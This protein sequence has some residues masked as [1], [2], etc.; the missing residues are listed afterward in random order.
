MPLTMQQISDLMKTGYQGQILPDSGL[1]A[2]DIDRIR[3]MAFEQRG[4]DTGAGGDDI[5]ALIEA[6]LAAGG[7]G[8]AGGGGYG[9]GAGAIPW[10][11][12]E[13]AARLAQQFAL[14]QMMKEQAYRTEQERLGRTFEAGEAEKQREFTRQQALEELKAERQRIFT[15]MMGKDPVRAAL[16]AMG[17]GGEILPGGERFV[18]LPPLAG[19]AEYG[20]KAAT[21]LSSLLGR[22]VGV[23]EQGVTGL[24]EVYK[25]A[26]AYSA[27]QRPGGAGRVGDIEAARTML[28]SGF[29]VGAKPGAGRPGLSPEE[30]LRK[31]QSVTPTGT[32]GR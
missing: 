21:G 22:Q 13:G 18:N 27:G 23:G 31:I 14:E 4:F 19:A 28:L 12:T 3:R 26:G 16:F 29:G 25:A 10:G 2:G 9:G 1:Q 7:L 20:R 32:I 24:P 8:G 6:A 30:A 15:E 17:V 5:D 11:S